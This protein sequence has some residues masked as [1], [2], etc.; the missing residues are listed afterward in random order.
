MYTAVG[1]LL[2][3]YPYLLVVFISGFILILLSAIISAHIQK[4]LKENYPEIHNRF[5]KSARANAWYPPFVPGWWLSEGEWDL[6][7]SSKMLPQNKN[8]QFYSK[9]FRWCYWGGYGSIL[10][11]GLVGIWISANK[12]Y[13]ENSCEHLLKSKQLDLYK[14]CLGN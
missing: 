1:H 3:E 11:V 7:R 5:I 12:V 14:Q 13:L 10:L 6:A 4:L 2:N 8:I 9:L